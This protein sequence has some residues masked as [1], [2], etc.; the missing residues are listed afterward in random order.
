MDGFAIGNFPTS[1]AL[2]VYNPQNWQYCK[3]DSCCIKPY[4]LPASA[5]LDIKYDGGLFCLLLCDENPHM[6][7]NYPPGTYVKRLDPSTNMF[8]FGT[9]MD[10]PFPAT[11]PTF[12]SLYTN[13]NYTILFDN[14]TLASIP[15]QDMA[16]HH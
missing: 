4:R 3:P 6:E 16:S 2:M 1:N 5:Y 9:V 15:L 8:L 11:S 13:L 12:D 10:V 7:E 14:G